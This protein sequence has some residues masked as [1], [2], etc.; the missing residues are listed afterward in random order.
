MTR[1]AAFLRGINVGGKNIIRMEDLTNS[2]C[3][4]GFE[5][6]KTLIQ[7]GNVIFDSESDNSAALE[8]KIT[9]SL[10][11]QFNFDAVVMLRTINEIEAII[12]LNPFK[13]ITPNPK[14]KFYIVFLDTEPKMLH[15]LPLV[16]EKERLELFL[17]H[18]KDAFLLSSEVKNGRYGFPNNF[19][20]KELGVAAT[21]RNWN[22]VCKLLTLKY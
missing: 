2:F 13:K 15:R 1:Y 10:S 16:N 17:V 12:K 11:S 19:V 3:K 4:M 5:N 21:S 8:K 14:I 7:S 6:V 22:T 18:K 20:E 9:I